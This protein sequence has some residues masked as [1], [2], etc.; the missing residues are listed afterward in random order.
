MEHLR[1]FL[2]LPVV[3]PFFRLLNSSKFLIALATMIVTYLVGIE[4]RL[5]SIAPLLIVG[6]ATLASVLI[7]AIAK[8]DVAN[9]SLLVTKSAIDEPLTIDL[10]KSQVKDDIK[11]AVNEAISEFFANR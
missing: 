9:K 7:Y 2:E 1:K 10:A 4:P 11:A 5:S 6:I 8:E 3:K